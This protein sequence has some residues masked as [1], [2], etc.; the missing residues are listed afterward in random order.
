MA[1]NTKQEQQEG[2]QLARTQRKD[3][4]VELAEH[5]ASLPRKPRKRRRLLALLIFGA[6]A[7]LLLLYGVLLLL[8]SSNP[9]PQAGVA[10]GKTA[11]TFA[12]P[13]YGGGGS[14]NTLVNLSA[15]R[16]H[17]V[18]LN[19]WSESCDPCRAEMPYLQQIYA[20][21]GA[22][23]QFVLLGINQ[24]DPKDDIAIFGR[25]FKIS[26]PLLFD[27]GG[28]VNTTYNVTAIPT[29][30]FIDRDGIV[31]TV[32]ITQLSP[33]TMKRGLASIGVEIP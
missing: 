29:T 5:Y 11:P 32:S 15:L 1:R 33:E 30:Y 8:P 19:F 21:Y 20:Q 4:E 17:P 6:L 3:L 25:Q 10:V 22:Q 14:L 26:Y 13:I 9:T 16:G 12:L 7:V 27:K 18:V 23:G 24:A 31:R 2:Y 28:A